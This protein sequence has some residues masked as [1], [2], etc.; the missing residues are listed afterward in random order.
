MNVGMYLTGMFT[1]AKTKTYY[2]QCCVKYMTAA[3]QVY[4]SF[5]QSEV[6]FV[7]DLT[8]VKS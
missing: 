3:G 7:G 2:E 5:Y 8:K 1:C 4:V 6:E